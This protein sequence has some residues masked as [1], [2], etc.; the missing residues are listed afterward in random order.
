MSRKFQ[1]LFFVFAS[2]INGLLFAVPFI[3]DKLFFLLF[4]AFVPLFL[5]TEKLKSVRGQLLYAFIL[6]IVWQ[7]TTMCWIH[8]EYLPLWSSVAAIFL[9]GTIT[10][11]S[12]L[13]YFCGINRLTVKKKYKYFLFI[14]VWISVEWLSFEWELAFPF[15]TLGYYLGNISFLVQWYQYTGVLGGTIWIL[16]INITI[17]NLLDLTVAKIT[18]W[19]YAAL[20]IIPV[21]LSIGLY[22]TPMPIGHTEKIVALNIENDIDYTNNNTFRDA[23][24]CISDN[25]D[26]K[27]FLV[28]CP[29]GICYLPSS[30]FPYNTYFSSIKNM[31]RQRAPQASVIF[32]ATTQ[33]VRQGG[34][35]NNN[36]LLNVAIYCNA[37]GFIN[38]RNKIRLVPFGEFIPYECIFGKIPTINTIVTTPR[39]YKNEYDSVVVINDVRTVT[40]ICY[41]LYF[42]NIIAKY[43]REDNVELLISISNDYI[44]YAPIFAEQ[45]IRMARVQAITFCKSVVKSTSRGI[46]LMIS[47]KGQ[48][49]AI[50]KFNASGIISAQVPINNTITLYGKYGNSM[51]YLFLLILFF[52]VFIVKL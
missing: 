28:V 7:F 45:L 22:F 31:L 39:I 42:S 33:D 18:K 23:L 27:V 17:L 47:P 24:H 20:A 19:G 2:T 40:L 25:I 13:I 38:F 41:E 3:V 35:F 15:H 26:E 4:I 21:V 16:F 10:F 1:I 9:S 30:S 8:S 34:T 46:S 11:I 50:S 44:M 6:V 36:K 32:G 14:L 5:I 29:E 52:V 43:V 12:F 37:D 51:A 48:I 49:L